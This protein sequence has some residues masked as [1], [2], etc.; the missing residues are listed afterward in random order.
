M[1]G[2]VSKIFGTYYLEKVRSDSTVLHYR[3]CPTWRSLV[4]FLG[5][6]RVA[7]SELNPAFVLI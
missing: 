7:L 6:S 5:E 2:I 4:L 3:R 1:G